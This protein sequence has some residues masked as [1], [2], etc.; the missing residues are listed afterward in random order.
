MRILVLGPMQVKVGKHNVEIARPRQRALLAVLALSANHTVHTD[1]IV[2]MVWGDR[3]PRHVK[4]QIQVHVSHI[5][6]ALRAVGADSHLKT[7]PNGYQLQLHPSGCDVA[8]FSA[9][10]SV[11]IEAIRENRFQA[12]TEAYR[13]ALKSWRGAALTGLEGAFVEPQAQL[14]Q[15]RRRSVLCRWVDLEIGFDRPH[16]LVPALMEANHRDPY[17]E[18]V[19]LRLMAALQRCGRTAEALN[20]YRALRRALS[21][22]LGLGPNEALRSAESALLHSTPIHHDAWRFPDLETATT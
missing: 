18:G 8:M 5:R 13:L 7:R 3:P 22:D 14:L 16:H 4:N 21:T 12:A 17:D 15:E 10:D 20:V 19:A 11:G 6:R 2:D 9:L 1:R